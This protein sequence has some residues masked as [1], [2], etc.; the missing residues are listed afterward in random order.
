MSTHRF[1]SATA[2]AA[3]LLSG[4]SACAAT[5][6]PPPS[7]SSALAARATAY[8]QS[9]ITKSG[10]ATRQG[11]IAADPRV[12]PLGSVVH[13][14]AP[15]QAHD[16]IYRVLDTGAAVRGR[17]VDIYMPNCRSAKRFGR[18]DVVI[19]VLEW[20]SGERSERLRRH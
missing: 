11:V 17:I 13:I 10:E 20:G 4:F 2:S 5:P 8:C 16:G 7:R 12:L 1:G 6:E 15:E 18:R 9:G 14:D 3:L 19:H